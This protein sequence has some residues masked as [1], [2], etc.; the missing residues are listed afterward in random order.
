MAGFSWPAMG[1]VEIEQFLG[2]SIIQTEPIA[3]AL[4]MKMHSEVSIWSTEAMSQ[5]DYAF[6]PSKRLRAI[7]IS[8]P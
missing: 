2:N 7:F 5:M 8:L 6:M 4:R 3:P 1:A